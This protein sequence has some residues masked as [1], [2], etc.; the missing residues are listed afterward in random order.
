MDWR[1]S[2]RIHWIYRSNSVVMLLARVLVLFADLATDVVV[3]VQVG[4]RW[5][6]IRDPCRFQA[7]TGLVVLPDRGDRCSGTRVGSRSPP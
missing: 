5:M 3:V 6:R 4:P 1:F 2:L 7:H